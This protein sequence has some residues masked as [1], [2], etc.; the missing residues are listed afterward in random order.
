[1]NKEAWCAA[2]HGVSES[3]TRLSDWSEM[4]WFPL[5]S[6]SFYNLAFILII[7]LI[8]CSAYS[9]ALLA[10]FSDFVLFVCFCISYHHLKIMSKNNYSSRNLYAGQEAT[11]RTG[12]GTTDWFQIR[13]GV[14]QGC[15]LS[16]CVFN[17]CRVYHEK[18]QAGWSTSWNQGCWKKYQ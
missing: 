9:H 5:H 17:I 6:S 8:Y 13:K 10:I 11:V 3:Q 14:L 1:M 12:H 15:I 2:V 7:L 4:N 18:C 16:L